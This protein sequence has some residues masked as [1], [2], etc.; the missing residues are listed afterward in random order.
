MGAAV[1]NILMGTVA[2]ID[3]QPADVVYRADL[4]FVRHPD[5]SPDFGNDGCY[6][7]C[8]KDRRELLGKGTCYVSAHS[9]LECVA[10]N[11]GRGS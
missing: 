10:Y 7:Q 1:I 5:D 11:M 8:T 4:V 2:E 6:W 3:A 9:A